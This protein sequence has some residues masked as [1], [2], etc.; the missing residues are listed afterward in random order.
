MVHDKLKKYIF[1]QLYKELSNAEIIPYKDSIWF[2]DREKEFW[3]FEFEKTGKLWWRF[4]FFY[5]FFKIFSFERKQFEFIISAWVE[6]VLNCK[7]STARRRCKQ[8]RCRVEEVLN[9]KVNSTQTGNAPPLSLVKEILDCK[10]SSV[11]SLSFQPTL[12]VDEVLDCKVST[13]QAGVINRSNW[14]KRVLSQK[15]I[16]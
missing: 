10:V 5:D 15:N 12:L 4:H 11:N 14:I 7:V 16:D 8:T 1:K 2:I 9:C 13:T 6:E 3:Y